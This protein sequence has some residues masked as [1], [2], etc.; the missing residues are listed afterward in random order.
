MHGSNSSLGTV[1]V[2]CTAD[3][4]HQ[5]PK[6]PEAALVLFQLMLFDRKLKVMKVHQHCMVSCGS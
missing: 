5:N 4:C 1:A 2:A 6:Q 3:I